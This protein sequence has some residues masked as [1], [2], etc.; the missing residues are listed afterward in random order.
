MRRSEILVHVSAPSRARDDARY[1]ALAEAAAVFEPVSRQCVFS[2]EEIDYSH[3]GSEAGSPRP[4]A[5]SSL[6]QEE[7]INSGD[8]LESAISRQ[9]YIPIDKVLSVTKSP[10]PHSEE[11]REFVAI[12]STNLPRGLPDN[13]G[14]YNSPS[15]H[16]LRL[17][18]NTGSPDSKGDAI[19]EQQPQQSCVSGS[20][21][22]PL[23]V[24]PDSQPIPPAPEADGR[25]S[26]HL[27]PLDVQVE[28]S[29]HSD[30][31]NTGK[32]R[33]LNPDS[34]AGSSA[35]DTRVPSS[36]LKDGEQPG[37]SNQE[38]QPEK[39]AS[40][41]T[42]AS[43]SH[44]SAM[45]ASLQRAVHESDQPPSLDVLPLML[46]PQSPPVSTGGFSTHITP[47]LRM[48]AERLKISRTYQPLRQARELDKLERGFW[49]VRI[50]IATLREGY[51]EEQERQ[52]SAHCP[53]AR[54]ANQWTVSFFTRF[55]SFLADFI[56]KEGRAG[57]GVW[58][59]LEDASDPKSDIERPSEG[60]EISSDD[61]PHLYTQLA[62]KVYT[63]G[64]VAPHV[65]L[66]L[67]LASER[68][69][70]G[71]GAQWKDSA[72]NTIIEMP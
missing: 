65:Y 12:S 61:V 32:R 46:H 11:P 47:T 4:T 54:K 72:E 50:C 33:R 16:Q 23:S 69:I 53:N 7:E 8:E 35:T 29:F 58:C 67:F 25:R 36:V 14:S 5:A 3:P 1:R 56:V 60:P 64:E 19:S 40:S 48:L 28:R 45:D 18:V 42:S 15:D 31:S 24:I 62:L 37:G 39:R 52:N 68:R 2:G 63:W 26:G 13:E 34:S 55:W 59:I 6:D 43:S 49:Y 38:N 70:R 27:Q 71:M 51:R 44:D 10:S 30:T 21:E 22:T 9:K 41:I 17:R 57:W 20:L 66:L